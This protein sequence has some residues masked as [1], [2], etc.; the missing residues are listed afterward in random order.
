MRELGC[1][2][3]T[4]RA[5]FPPSMV[6]DIAPD[7]VLL[8]PGPGSPDDFDLI[9]LVGEISFKKIPLFGVCLG[10]QAIGQ[11]FGAELSKLPIPFHGKPSE[12]THNNGLFHNSINNPFTAGRYHSLYLKN[13]S[14]P[15]CLEVTA[16]TEYTHSDGQKEIIPM[17]ITH[18]NLPI[19]SVQ[20]HPESLMTLDK[21]AGHMILKNAIEVLTS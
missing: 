21:N 9:P 13:D 20:F 2:V 4:L 12:I 6:F 1:E 14:I 7:L 17:A 8:S 11:H 15:E 18:K 5:G 19:A 3:I 16:H 10:H